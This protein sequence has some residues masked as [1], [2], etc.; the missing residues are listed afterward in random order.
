MKIKIDGRSFIYPDSDIEWFDSLGNVKYKLIDRIVRSRPNKGDKFEPESWNNFNKTEL[1]DKTVWISKSRNSNDKNFEI[2]KKAEVKKDMVKIRV[3]EKWHEYPG[4]QIVSWDSEGNIEWSD[5]IHWKFLRGRPERG[6]EFVYDESKFIKQDNITISIKFAKFILKLKNFLNIDLDSE[7]SVIIPS[8]VLLEEKN[9]EKIDNSDF[10]IRF[11]QS[12]IS[13]YEEYVGS[14]T[15]L[16]VSNFQTYKSLTSSEFIINCEKYLIATPTDLS[17]VKN[18]NY[19]IFNK[20]QIDYNFLKEL[21]LEKYNF[22]ARHPTA[23]LTILILLI[24]IGFRNINLYGFENRKDYKYSYYYKEDKSE[25]EYE[26]ESKWHEYE[27]EN[28]IINFNNK[29]INII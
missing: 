1:K 28:K 11:N 13:D 9:G 17:I 16:L 10:V 21:L 4:D 6:D 7:I 8:K 19:N 15:D 25:E 3:G 18:I 29:I 5:K 22:N 23:G 14:K 20:L 27:L 2:E 26:K 24:E 12:I